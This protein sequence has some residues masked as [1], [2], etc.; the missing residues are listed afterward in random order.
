MASPNPTRAGGVLLIAGYL[1]VAGISF[2]ALNPALWGDPAGRLLEQ[3]GF[4][5]RYSQGADV[6]AAAYPWFQPLVWLGSSAPAGWHPEVFFYFG[7]DGLIFLLALGGLPPAWRD[8]GR[9][10]LAVWLVGGALLLLLWPTRWPQYTLPLLPAVC[11]LAAI[12]L[13]R[14]GAR[15]RELEDYWGWAAEMLPRP[16]RYAWVAIVLLLGFMLSIYGYGLAGVAIGG[17][18]WSRV[19][20]AALP[21][22]AGP[23]Y[24]A[25]G[26]PDGRVAIAGERGTLL[27]QALAGA[28]Q[29]PRWLSL[30]IA[31]RALALA[32]DPAGALWVGTAG[33]LVR[34]ADLPD[35][36]GPPTAGGAGAA[37]ATY[38][39]QDF[40]VGS[41]AV[42]ALAR[43]GD[44]RLWVGTGAGAAVRDPGGAWAPLPQ[45][46]GGGLVSAVAVEPRPAGDRIWFGGAGGVSRLDTATGAWEQFGRA[47]G[48]GAAGVGALLVD[49]RGRVWAG[50]LGAGLA[51]WEG[52]VW[53]WL[54]PANSGLPY[55][56]VT[57]LAEP[58]PGVIWV[59]CALPI[60]A[61]G[62]ALASYDGAEWRAYLPRNSGFTGAEPLAMARDT[63]GRL[64]IATRGGELVIYQLP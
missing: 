55:S 52:G 57:A 21:Q 51:R 7:F 48:F 37:A 56:V 20:P 29:A 19:A 36:A 62:G 58:Q 5:L 61:G 47:A 3:A 10:W 25:L 16:P 40:G 27:G 1:L 46:A 26:L 39:A 30:P 35:G 45:A 54:T 33:G 2:F 8:P 9:R 43:G 17:M 34:L 24:A 53:S 15:L 28:D 50:T 31:G 18:G 49:S 59:G 14:I 32:Y 23:L 11:A 42:Y 6:A 12:S 4:H 22:P 60:E 64:W 41:D 63:Q 44:G 13:R 38:R